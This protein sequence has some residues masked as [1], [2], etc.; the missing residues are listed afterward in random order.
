LSGKG[1]GS[2]VPVRLSETAPPASSSPDPAVGRAAVAEEAGASGG[3]SLPAFPSSLPTV[4]P[5]VAEDFGAK[6]GRLLYDPAVGADVLAWFERRADEAHSELALSFL[7]G[8]AATVSVTSGTARAQQSDFLSWTK[9]RL[10]SFPPESSR[11]CVAHA[12]CPRWRVILC[13]PV[14]SGHPGGTC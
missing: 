12:C 11:P 6:L 2:G 8:E 5:V 3:G 14:D 9:S 1:V 13:S 4:G 10:R 7:C